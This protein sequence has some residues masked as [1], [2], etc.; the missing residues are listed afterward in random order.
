MNSWRGMSGMDSLTRMMVI[1]TFIRMRRGGRLR[2]I[3]CWGCV[4]AK[5][6]DCFSRLFW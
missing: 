6:D 3:R 4:E 2:F 1:I 5:I